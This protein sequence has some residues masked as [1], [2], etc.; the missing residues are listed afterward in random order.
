MCNWVTTLYRRKLTEHCKPAIMKK[1]KIITNSKIKNTGE[2]DF[3][4]PWK[5][6]LCSMYLKGINI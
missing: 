6:I 1:K 5:K 3:K 2:A 4:L